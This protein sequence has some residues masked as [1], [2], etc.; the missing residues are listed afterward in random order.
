VAL[1]VFCFLY[2]GC[3]YFYPINK[4]N[5]GIRK[6][7]FRLKKKAVKMLIK[8]KVRYETFCELYVGKYFVF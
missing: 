6:R 7:H 5:C 1:G 3:R 4:E 2:S 8:V